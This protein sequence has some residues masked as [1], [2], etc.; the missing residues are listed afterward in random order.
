MPQLLD[1]NSPLDSTEITSFNKNKTII[2][3]AVE[4]LKSPDENYFSATPQNRSPSNIFRSDDCNELLEK[5]LDSLNEE[6][7]TSG[8]GLVSQSSIEIAIDDEQGRVGD[9]SKKAEAEPEYLGEVSGR[10]FK[11]SFL[12]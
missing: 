5:E 2:N 9:E 10:F 8:R 1:L 12:G 3:A 4:N 11:L 7:A 6:E